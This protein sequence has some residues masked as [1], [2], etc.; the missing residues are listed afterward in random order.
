MPDQK[1]NSEAKLFW[2]LSLRVV[3]IELSHSETGYEPWSTAFNQVSEK[4]V[5]SGVEELMHSLY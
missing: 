3:V 4:I 5:I 2:V 1:N